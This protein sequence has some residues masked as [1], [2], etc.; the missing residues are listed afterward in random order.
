MRWAKSCFSSFP[1]RTSL[2]VEAQDLAPQGTVIMVTASLGRRHKWSEV[3]A[4]G[5]R[6]PLPTQH[7]GMLPPLISVPFYPIENSL[8]RRGASSKRRST[9]RQSRT[10]LHRLTGHFGRRGHK[11]MKNNNVS[12]VST[13]TS[14]SHDAEASCYCLHFPVCLLSLQ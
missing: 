2:R 8:G 6:R 10:A 7:H 1:S 11:G 3:F 13:P 5:H 12:P 4:Q 14:P 9:R